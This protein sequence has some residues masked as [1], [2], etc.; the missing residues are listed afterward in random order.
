[1][2]K[3][4]LEE[5]MQ[6]TSTAGQNLVGIDHLRQSIRDILTTRKGTRV[7]CRDYGSRLPELVDRPVNPAFE[8]DVYAATAEALARWEPR[9]ELSQVTIAEAAAGRIV[10]K[11][12][13]VYRPDGTNLILQALEVT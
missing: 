13:G 5:S 3:P 2:A 10:L 7:M 9:F 11:L 12:E 6:G 4:P 1:M 8:M